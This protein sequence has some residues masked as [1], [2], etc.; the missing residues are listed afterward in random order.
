MA[1]VDL[2]AAVV[3]G[4]RIRNV[5]RFGQIVNTFAK[6]GLWSVV[7][8]L[9]IRHV[10]S[11]EQLREA[12]GLSQLERLDGKGRESVP[13]PES[14]T[15]IPEIVVQGLP[16]RLRRSFE[17]LGPAWVKLGQVLATREDL[18]PAPVIEELKKLHTQVSAL[19]YSA[20]E[21]TLKEE[22]GDAKLAQFQS[23]ERTPLA[24][25]SIAQVHRATLKD[26]RK[27]I[28]K[29]Q[30]PQIAST[31]ETDLSLMEVIASLMERYLPESRSFRPTVMIEEFGRATRGELDFV[32]EGGTTSKISANFAA[33]DY[34]V[35]PE[36]H[37]QLS[38]PRVLAQSFLEGFSVYDSDK[39]K[40]HGINP[41]RLVE[42]GLTAFVQMVFVDGFYHGD[43]HPGNML[44][45]PDGRIGILDFG[46]GVLIGRA[47][48]ERLAGLLMA[49]VEEDFETMVSHF[50]DLSSP[51][52]D[53][54]LELFTHEVSNA[55][56]PF[57]GLR[58]SEIRSGRLLWDLARIAGRHGAPM[59]RELVL[60]LRTMAAFEGI[61][62]KLDPNF[63]VIASC[64]KFTG[65]LVGQMY[66]AENLKRQG[67]KGQCPD[68]QLR[69]PSAR[70]AC[71]GRCTW[72]I[73]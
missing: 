44:I 43:L 21:R 72:S 40:A 35:I 33:V 4:K 30:R 57:V 10:L 6:H 42:K 13:D 19:D 3:L 70:V 27:I 60:F 38:T 56:A 18:L 69:R 37:W 71:G 2:G 45:L 26:G 49:L 1:M 12:E 11:P 51:G 9:K 24:A 8:A 36:V 66:S 62:L 59:P 63:D 14:E 20:I 34:I 39:L 16:A 23:I 46:V 65:Q 32:R 15:S 5:Q 73:G 17:E 52:P 68:A 58:L 22:L 31:I 25:G 61:G 67:L 28:L 54:D 64:E 29:V 48:R 55:M 7:E 47:A 50:V 41:V 53:F